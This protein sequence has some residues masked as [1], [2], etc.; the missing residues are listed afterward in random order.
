MQLLVG[1]TVNDNQVTND[2]GAVLNLAGQPVAVA[3]PQINDV[4]TWIAGEWK[5]QALP[6]GITSHA[7]LTGLAA[8]DHPHY[9]NVARGDARYSLLGHNHDALYAA[10]TPTI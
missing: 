6:T 9:L 1:L 4:L 8:D 2:D 3:T 5:P 7:A 10:L